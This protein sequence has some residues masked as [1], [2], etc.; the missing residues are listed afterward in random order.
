MSKISKIDGFRRRIGRSVSDVDN[1]DSGSLSNPTLSPRATFEKARDETLER[2]NTAIRI[3][4]V[5]IQ[6]YILE[7]P[8]FGSVRFGS[9]LEAFFENRELNRG[10][11][12][13]ILLN[14]GL[15]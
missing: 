1:I 6:Q 12:R 5:L 9:V 4:N 10:S 7:M 11:V 14:F 8:W 2:L 13:A 15:T 3:A